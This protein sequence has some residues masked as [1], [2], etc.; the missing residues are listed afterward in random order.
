MCNRK[1]KPTGNSINKAPRGIKTVH[2]SDRLL[3]PIL[4]QSN[5][6]RYVIFDSVHS[7]VAKQTDCHYESL[8]ICNAGKQFAC[9][10][11]VFNNWCSWLVARVCTCDIRCHVAAWKLNGNEKVIEM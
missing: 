10:K 1:Y 5:F 4:L 11:R 9:S 2:S 3:S 6:H 7:V 8:K